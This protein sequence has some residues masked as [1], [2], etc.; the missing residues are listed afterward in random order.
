MKLKKY[1][2]I[3]LCLVVMMSLL[4]LSTKVTATEFG[5]GDSEVIV[6][7]NGNISENN[8]SYNIDGIAVSLTVLGTDITDAG[9]I[10]IDRNRLNDVTF[11]IGD[12]Y[13][14]QTM[15]VIIRGTDNY[16]CPLNV[17]NNTAS[18]N[19]LNFPDGVLNLS[20]E[21]KNNGGNPNDNPPPSDNNYPDDIQI[22]GTYNSDGLGMNITFNGVNVGDESKNVV[23]TAKGY[24]TGSEKNVIRIQLAFGDGNLGSVTINGEEMPLP[25]GVGDF[26][27]FEVDPASEYTIVVTKSEDRSNVPCT[28]IWTNP[29]YKPTSEEDAEWVS[30]FKVEHG[31]A[32]VIAVYDETGKKL[33]PEE[34]IGENSDEF[35][36]DNGFGWVKVFPKYKAVF[37]FVPEYGYQLTEIKLSDQPMGASEDMNFFTVTIPEGGA[38]IH[39]NAVFTETKDVVTSS[40][41]KVSGGSIE[42]GN[43]LPGGSAQL[44]VS[45]VELSSDKIS[46][47]ENAAGEYSI[48]NYLDIDLY[49]VY[50]KGKDDSEDVWLDKIS[51]LENEATISIKLEEGVNADDIVIVHNVHDGDE[52]EIIQIDSY[53][54]ETNTITFKT[55]S[56]SSYAIAT[57]T[58][59]KTTKPDETVKTTEQAAKSDT[60]TNITNTTNSN[61]PKTG[62]NSNMFFWIV[63]MFVGSAG[64]LGTTIY[65]RKKFTE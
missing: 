25:E 64:V 19:G 41:E 9:E 59:D 10:R 42:L 8:V 56:F 11:Q 54:P 58:N 30:D 33:S 57:K 29:D 4:P 63:L 3:V 36:L 13:D 37:E 28:I 20:I 6:V 1:L 32:K 47:F 50:Y 51:E 23:G 22:N 55:K 60:V 14:E 31:Y 65:S 5:S 62:D 2:S 16:S 38:N 44:S 61:S 49:N 12:T 7:F 46:G 15:Q 39:F 18:L 35:G 43:T 34:Y 53:D 24:A 40:S 45:D 21:S 26:A 27:E 17:N 52:Y 48:S